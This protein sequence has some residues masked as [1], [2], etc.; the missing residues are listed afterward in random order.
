MIAVR[1]KGVNKTVVAHNIQSVFGTARKHVYFPLSPL[2]WQN[3]E[4]SSK[5]AVGLFRVKVPYRAWI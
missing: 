3:L 4:I 5:T 2:V 1:S